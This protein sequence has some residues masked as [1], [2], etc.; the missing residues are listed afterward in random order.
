MMA[1]LKQTMGTPLTSNFS[2]LAITMHRGAFQVCA[3]EPEGTAL[4]NLALLRT[5][6]A[7]ILAE[8]PYRGSDWHHNRGPPA[9]RQ[10]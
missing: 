8:Q 7:A 6:L 10:G 4:Y 5:L 2:M 9:A 1:P 3:L